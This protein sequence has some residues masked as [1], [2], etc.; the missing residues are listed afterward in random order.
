VGKSDKIS[1]YI[2]IN[3]TFH[4]TT[5]E[6]A[7]AEIYSNSEQG[8]TIEKAKESLAYLSLNTIQEA[9]ARSPLQIF[10]D[11]IFV[12]ETMTETVRHLKY[13]RM[14]P[15]LLISINALLLGMLLKICKCPVQE[16]CLPAIS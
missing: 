8:L 11:I 14:K 4:G 5:I 2:H 15:P 3:F 16:R 9:K 13:S 1:Q 12:A 6:E 10:Y 7:T